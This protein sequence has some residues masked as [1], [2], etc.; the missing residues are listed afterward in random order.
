MS[1]LRSEFIETPSIRLHCLIQGSD[2]SLPVLF[3]HGSYASSRWWLPVFSFLPDDIRAVAVDLRGCGHS[4]KPDEGYSIP[5][6]ADDLWHCVQGLGLADFDLVGHST[7]GAIATEFALQHMHSLHSLTLLDSVPIEGVYSPVETLQVLSQMREDHDLLTE[8]LQSLMPAFFPIEDGEVERQA[9]FD[10]LVEDAQNMA[11]AA[12]TEVAAAVSGW[13]RIADA[14]RL[15][16]PT[17]LLWGELDQI[18]ERDAMTRTLL[19]IPGANNLE[20]L[21]GVGH[22]PMIEAPLAFAELLINFIT[23]DYAGFDEIKEDAEP[24]DDEEYD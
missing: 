15:T 20:I 13:N 8:A 5:E 3:V 18:V 7:G 6:Q 1:S 21:S 17:S 9:Y 11:P 16:L 12:F 4:D 22:S 14:R 19:A 23:E 2:D 24:M 10:A